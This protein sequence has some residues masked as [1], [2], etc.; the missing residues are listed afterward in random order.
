MFFLINL[1]L[2]DSTFPDWRARD[3]TKEAIHQIPLQ[4]HYAPI[5][6][7]INITCWLL[8]MVQPN[9]PLTIWVRLDITFVVSNRKTLYE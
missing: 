7:F 1:I 5:F 9:A 4:Y 3:L 2:P 8:T 6:P